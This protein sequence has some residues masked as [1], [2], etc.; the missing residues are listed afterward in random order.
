MTISLERPLYQS[1][2]FTGTTTAA[3]A[4]GAALFEGMGAI[5]VIKNTGGTNGLKYKAV[6]YLDNGADALATEMVS[7]ATVAFGAQSALI[8]GINAPFVKAA[9]QVIDAVGA[10][11]TTFQIDI[12]KY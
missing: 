1:K 7:E 4:D 9:V 11:H 3:Y 2:T 5:F 8:S 6:I 10:S 12:M